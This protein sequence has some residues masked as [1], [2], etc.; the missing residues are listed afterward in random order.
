MAAVAH[1]TTPAVTVKVYK[2][3]NSNFRGKNLVVNRRN[4]RTMEALYD[5]ITAHIEPSNAVRN[6]YTPQGGRRV[7]SLENLIN[8][9]N[10][11]AAGREGFK[12][13]N[14]ANLGVAKP[15]P[16]HRANNFSKKGILPAEGRHKMDY[17]G[18]K[19][20]LK[21]I[22][23]F[24]NG[25]VFKPSV[26]IVLQKRLQQCMEQILDIVQEHVV[27]SAA[28]ASLYTI[29]GK[30]ILEPW[31]LITGE[32]YVAVERGK[33]FKPEN[34]SLGGSSLTK[35]PRRPVL[36]PIGNGQMTNSEGRSPRKKIGKK[37]LRAGKST[38]EKKSVD[39]SRDQS[40]IATMSVTSPRDLHSNLSTEDARKAPLRVSQDLD[41]TISA[42][43]PVH[44]DDETPVPES[45]AETWHQDEDE[46]L[47]TNVFKASGLQSVK[48][49]EIRDT[50][51]TTL[52][53]PIDSFPAEEV[54]EEVLEDV[55]EDKET[56][57]DGRTLQSNKLVSDRAEEI[58]EDGVESTTDDSPKAVESEDDKKE[59]H[60]QAWTPGDD[61]K[62]PE[63]EGKEQEAERGP[64]KKERSRS[65]P[66]GGD[67]EHASTSQ[68]QEDGPASDTGATELEQA[69]GVVQQRTSPQEEPVGAEEEEKG[70]NESSEEQGSEEVSQ[71]KNDSDKAKANEEG[72]SSED[73]K[74]AINSTPE[75]EPGGRHTPS[76]SKP[77]ENGNSGKDNNSYF[78]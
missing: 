8:R 20:Y 45:D 50:R 77:P 21:I 11:V 52:E 18:E 23:V 47:D 60:L 56:I 19:R 15:R 38:N 63:S 16:P 9:N 71:P 49:E 29:D 41:F 51:Q 75:N 78:S 12:K 42:T 44:I 32:N 67:K 55:E 68:D 37:K 7:E 6:I 76:D 24:C 62:Q 58:V 35:S 25:N 66:M 57:G 2:N 36:P 13:L 34:Y 74:P 48:G 53:K 59:G 70:A 26:K 46:S 28:I 14:Y 3:G 43:P 72:N 30:R 33:S 64:L 65:S 10:Y 61:D 31:Q 69:D 5:E 17:E 27:L 40:S 1:S 22:Y 4:I 39:R 73:D 54:T